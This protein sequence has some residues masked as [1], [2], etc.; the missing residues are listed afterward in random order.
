M[1]KLLL[2]LFVPALVAGLAG[3]MTSYPPHP[4][5]LVSI[6]LRPHHNDVRVY[7]EGEKPQ[8]PNY[9]EVVSLAVPLTYGTLYDK[10]NALEIQGQRIGVDAILVTGSS[11]DETSGGDASELLHA[12]GIKYCDRL[13]YVQEYL[14]RKDVYTYLPD[15]STPLVYRADFDLMGDEGAHLK[16]RKDTIYHRYVQRYAFDY[17]MHAIWGWSYR[18]D[19]QGNII[20]RMKREDGTPAVRCWFEYN[21]YGNVASIRLITYANA[22]IMP[23][24]EE[25]IVLNYNEYQQVTEK[26]IFNKQKQLKYRETIRYEQSG[27]VQQSTLYA[28]RRDGQVPIVTTVHQY[29]AL[30]DLPTVAN[31]R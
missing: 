15:G 24:T 21:Q 12:V 9:Y 14:K 5:L 11:P 1:R 20:Q 27:R 6:P 10:V 17:L 28:V 30:G 18:S 16:Y 31:G 22:R 23:N 25:H 29:Y 3:C 8:N 4:R 26:L 7:L 2:L 13:D 19:A